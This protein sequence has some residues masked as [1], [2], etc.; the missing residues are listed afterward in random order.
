VADGKTEQV[1]KKPD[2]KQ[3]ITAAAPEVQTPGAAAGTDHGAGSHKEDVAGQAMRAVGYSVVRP[4]P[5]EAPTPAT[6]QFGNITLTSAD[7]KVITDVRDR[8]ALDQLASPSVT[9]QPKEGNGAQV[10][11]RQ[12]TADHEFA[13]ADGAKPMKQGDWVVT[14]PDGKTQLVPKEQFQKEFNPAAYKPDVPMQ[15]YIKSMPIDAELITKPTEWH[16][17]DGAPG[18][19]EIA[20]PGDYWAMPKGQF[21][22]GVQEKYVI[23]GEYFKNNYVQIPGSG[24]YARTS[25]TNA[26]VLDKAAAVWSP[27][28]GVTSGQP[29]DFLIT[30]DNG[31]QE[32]LS[33]QKFKN[34]F[35]LADVP[36]EQREPLNKPQPTGERYTLDEKNGITAEQ[37]EHGLTIYNGQ[38]ITITDNRDAS[39][40]EYRDG[41]LVGQITSVKTDAGDKIVTRTY[42]YGD[43]QT[44]RDLPTL[45]SYKN[46][47]ETRPEL[48]RAQELADSMPMTHLINTPERD[49][50]REQVRDNVRQ[51][52]EAMR[53]APADDGSGAHKLEQGRNLHIVMG[54]SGS[55]KSTVAE[56]IAAENHSFIPDVDEIKPDL[57]EWFGD[58]NGKKVAGIGAAATSVEAHMIMN[59]IIADSLKRGDNLVVPVVGATT[60]HLEKL[61]QN[62]KANGYEVHL[63]LVDVP[64]TEAM[65]RIVGRLEKGGLYVDP[66]YLA[67]LGNRPVQNF[68]YLADKYMAD[69]TISSYHQINNMGR[70][71]V[72]V[73]EGHI[74]GARGGSGLPD[75]FFGRVNTVHDEAKGDAVWRPGDQFRTSEAAPAAAAERTTTA[76]LDAIPASVRQAMIVPPEKRTDA[77]RDEVESYMKQLGM[78]A[79][80]RGEF[81]AKVREGVARGVPAFILIAGVLGYAASEMRERQTSGI[82]NNTYR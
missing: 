29:G 66:T 73:D 59:P 43:L 3:P 80:S 9:F 22:D 62:A 20:Q 60:E 30:R 8:A 67:S 38:T 55:G 48:K 35:A 49:A 28:S 53:N 52:M 54:L 17:P 32:I 21:R 24:E 6:E 78:D 13:A 57:P 27:S 36:P 71:P 19:T 63:S 14:A 69:G 77:Q 18:T 75:E 34:Q 46:L 15:K 50:L 41:R 47:L 10:S 37:W 44:V 11:A 81:E 31:N 7:G 26:Q 76:A 4:E 45:D 42:P 64:P 61:I 33:A 25:I 2:E 51:K 5:A 74:S 79:K 40:K 23:P 58:I 72:L 39:A 70:P 56:K 1:T 12:L 65:K 82:T 68:K 16:N